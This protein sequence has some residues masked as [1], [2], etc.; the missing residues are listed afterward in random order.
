MWRNS[1]YATLV[2]AWREDFISAVPVGTR[3]DRGRDILGRAKGKRSNAEHRT[4]NTEHRIVILL[5]SCGPSLGCPYTC[6][7]NS[8]PFFR[9]SEAC[10][11][12]R[13][14]IHLLEP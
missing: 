1:L 13:I 9:F 8:D 3:A 5:A 2:M 14:P 6:D 12:T 7:E 4:S 10:D 11:Q